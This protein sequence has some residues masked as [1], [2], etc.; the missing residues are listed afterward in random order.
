MTNTIE[1]MAATSHLIA[2]MEKEVEI[3]HQYDPAQIKNMQTQKSAFADS[4][5]AW[6]GALQSDLQTLDPLLHKE[7]IEATEKCQAAIMDNLRALKAMRDVSERILQS[8]IHTM[9]ETRRPVAT[10][11]NQGGAAR[12]RRSGYASHA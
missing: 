1:L 7:L 4:Y 2:C 8:I 3:I 5:R 10:Y 12:Q 9:D 11:T 6:A